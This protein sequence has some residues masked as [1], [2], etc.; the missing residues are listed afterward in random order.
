MRKTPS[1]LKGLAETRARV[2][3]DLARYQEL[4]NEIG[5]KLAEAKAEL[6]ACD[7]LIRK[8]DERLN[9][10][11]I[12]PIRAWKGR[13]GKRGELREQIKRLLQ[14][15]APTEVTTTELAWELQLHF[16]LDFES[17][18]E[19]RKWTANSLASTLKALVAEGC[20]ERLHEFEN[21]PTGEAGRWRWKLDDDLSL[22][23]L[24]AQLA[25]AG[26]ATQ[27]CDDDPV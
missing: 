7:R 10:N 27:Q 4:Y 12:E 19:K 25:A 1:Y 24:E 15:R 21:G 17:A 18:Q 3:G 6:E 16:R 23:R 26:I 22:D 11:L 20:V 5:Q 14:Q 9:P 8:F 2:A 13:Y